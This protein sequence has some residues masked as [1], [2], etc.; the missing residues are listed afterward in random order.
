MNKGLLQSLREEYKKGTR[1]RLLN[2]DDIQ[3]PPIGTLGTV[4]GVDDMGSL[5]VHWDTGSSLN[6]I[7]G[8]DR[9]EIVC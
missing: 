9:V 1:V 6:V 7:Y 8:E 5:L 4:F 2:M 3:A